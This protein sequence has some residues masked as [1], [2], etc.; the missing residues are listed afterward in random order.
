VP[1]RLLAPALALD[2][3][4]LELVVVSAPL[5]VAVAVF[6][7]PLGG[8]LAMAGA[9]IGAALLVRRLPA[10]EQ[11]VDRT[12][13]DVDQGPAYWANPRFLF[14]LLVSIVF[15]AVFGTVETGALP[16]ASNLGGGAGSAAALI[17]VISVSS[18][19]SGLAY[20]AFAH[21]LRQN[22]FQQARIMLGVW[23]LAGAG[24]TL[25]SGWVEAIGAMAVLGLCA[26]PLSTVRSQAAEIEVPLARRSEAFTVLFA[27]H[28][29]SYGAGGLLLAVLPLHVALLAGSAT[30]LFALLA[31]PVLLR[32]RR[33][34][35]R[36]SDSGYVPS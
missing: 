10:G 2:S 20:A 19:V 9:T 24:L 29:L 31:S 12:I 30:G 7:T 4:I 18:V 32:H 1:K 16:L 21:H 36:R 3:T 23:V 15:G 35:Q 8:V 17:A 13:A 27:A 5:V 6:A 11:P 33:V 22:A 25:A 34:V 14:W 26:A 28:S